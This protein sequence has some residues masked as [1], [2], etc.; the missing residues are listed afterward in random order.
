[1]LYGMGTVFVFLIVLVGATALM[2]RLVLR[3]APEPNKEDPTL[4]AAI[5]AAVHRYRRDINAQ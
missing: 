1:M 3:W 4:V 2:T 5:T